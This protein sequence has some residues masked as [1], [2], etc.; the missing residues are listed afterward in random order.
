VGPE[1]KIGSRVPG[2]SALAWHRTYHRVRILDQV[3]S[4]IF[5]ICRL[6][7]RQRQQWRIGR[8]FATLWLFT[9]RR[10]PRK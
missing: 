8:R 1:R 10:P 3:T 2:A 4:A 9:N 6:L 7:S 5:K